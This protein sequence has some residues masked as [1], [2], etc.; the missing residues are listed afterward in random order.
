[1]TPT[2]G[3]A[4]VTSINKVTITAP[5]TS[6]TLTIANGKTLTASNTLTFTGTDSSSV[7]F[8]SGGTVAYTANKLSVFAA[9]TS[10][11][12]AGVISDGTGTGALVF[13]TNPTISG[14][15]TTSTLAVKDVRDTVYTGGSTTGT[16]TPDCANG[17]I[18][19][20][21]LTGNITFNAFAN[22]VSGQ[23][24]TMIITQPA[25]GGPYTLTSSMKFAGGV[26]TLSTAASAVD[27]LTVSYIGTTYYASLVTGFA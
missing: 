26:K 17:N 1:V 10:A 16:V 14:T 21:T 27:M 9:T 15:V 5:A 24:M 4:S 25:S 8:G 23:S 18:Q 13:G 20:V 7:A 12:L 19:T 22:A 2:L 11:E 6:A 3:V